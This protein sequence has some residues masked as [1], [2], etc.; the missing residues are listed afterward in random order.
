VADTV[1]ADADIV[2]ICWQSGRVVAANTVVQDSAANGP[3]ANSKLSSNNVRKP[4]PAQ[5]WPSRPRSER[6]NADTPARRAE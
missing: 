3:D 4:S 6:S 1:A 5:C 2:I